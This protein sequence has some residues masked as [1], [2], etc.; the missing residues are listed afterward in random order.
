M[1]R[2]MI[3]WLSA[4]EIDQMTGLRFP[5]RRREWRLGRWTA[6][7]AV[8]ACLGWS[9]TLAKLRFAQHRPAHLRCVARSMP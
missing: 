2:R 4:A 7:H 1:S 6:K 8:A 5:K 3:G 9:G